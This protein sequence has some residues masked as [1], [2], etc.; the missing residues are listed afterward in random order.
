LSSGATRPSASSASRS[1]AAA[2]V[3][4]VTRFF[5]EA[6]LLHCSAAG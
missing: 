3:R 1:C 4:D 2:T 6:A 5:R